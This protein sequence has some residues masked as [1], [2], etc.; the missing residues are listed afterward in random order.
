MELDYHL[1]GKENNDQHA[2]YFDIGPFEII[3]ITLVIIWHTLK[4]EE[5][6][7]KFL[8]YNDIN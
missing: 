2:V 8:P 4:Y 5:F 7:R 6:L 1:K 3:Q